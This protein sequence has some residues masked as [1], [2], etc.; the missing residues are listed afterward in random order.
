MIDS[1]TTYNPTVGSQYAFTADDIGSKTLTI[2]YTYKP[3]GNDSTTTVKKTVNISVQRNILQSIAASGLV[4][5]T[6]YEGEYLNLSGATVEA[7]YSN[8][9]D[10]VT[11]GSGDYT[12]TSTKVGGADPVAITEPLTTDYTNVRFSR[13]EPMPVPIRRSPRLRIRESP[14]SPPQRRWSSSRE[15]LS[16]QRCL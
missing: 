3:D 13:T 15:R 12:V 16:F 11:L 14:S 10:E 8:M 7:T 9:T 5:T 6:Y 2:K 1:D 4:Q